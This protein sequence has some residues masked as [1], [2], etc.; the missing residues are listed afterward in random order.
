[1]RDGKKKR[2][3][4]SYF[5]VIRMLI[6]T[7]LLAA[8]LYAPQIIFRI[9]DGILCS[10]TSFDKREKMDV[11]TLSTTYERQLSQRMENFAEG[12]EAGEHYYAAS[13]ELAPN[14]E[15][16]DF[17]NSDL[18]LRQ[19]FI[20]ALI[21]TGWLHY[22][23]WE[24][25]FMV[26]NWKQYVIYS[27]DYAKGVNFIC[28]YMELQA[29]SGVILKL[30]ADAETGTIYALK[31][32]NR[33]PDN[34]LLVNSSW[35]PNLP[36]VFWYF[37]ADYFEVDS[38]VELEK[39]MQ[40]LERYAEEMYYSKFIDKPYADKNV[41]SIKEQSKVTSMISE[42][43][44]YEMEYDTLRLILPYGDNSLDV[45][46]SIDGESFPDE[47]Y[48]GLYVHYHEPNILAGFRQIYEL[49]PEFS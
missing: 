49:I 3:G 38:S 22:G 25:N 46:F 35:E 32:E 12:M 41:I 1:M 39:I 31:T 13:Q 18:G 19:E 8:A 45:M 40:E 30:L 27:D 16:Y 10:R 17:F 48:G 34:Q 2:R 29:E 20:Q 9:Q 42:N 26:N 37:F 7:V 4:A 44:G 11:E 24:Q 47:E 28:W 43:A 6:L 33:N 5:F 21:E 15:L 36:V 14:Q 23:F